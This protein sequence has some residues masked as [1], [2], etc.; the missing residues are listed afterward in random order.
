VLLGQG[1]YSN[2]NVKSG[3]SGILLP[4]HPHDLSTHENFF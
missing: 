2:L 1:T 4:A 3:R